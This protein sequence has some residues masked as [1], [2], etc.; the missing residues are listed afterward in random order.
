MGATIV[1]VRKEGEKMYVAQDP[2][3]A[4]DNST[5][6][7]TSAQQIQ[8]SSMANMHSFANFQGF[9]NANMKTFVWT[10]EDATRFVTQLLHF[11]QL[12]LKQQ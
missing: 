3:L 5:Y 8:Q 1:D 7:E 11:L 6:D 4:L 2:Y 10:D 9:I 12:Y